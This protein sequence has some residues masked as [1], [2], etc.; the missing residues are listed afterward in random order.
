MSSRCFD[1]QNIKAEALRLGFSACG[2]A[3]AEPVQVDA[4]KR[5]T[6]WIKDGK[7]AN[8]HYMGKH[9]EKRLAPTPCMDGTKSIIS[10]ALYYYPT[11][12]LNIEAYKLVW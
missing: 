10:V 11:Q 8:M 7:Q 12:Q 6:S 5:V 4:A 2:I 1:T 9:L 3:R